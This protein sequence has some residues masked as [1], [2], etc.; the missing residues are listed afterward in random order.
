MYEYAPVFAKKKEKQMTYGFMALGL[1][2]Y[3]IGAFVP[4][5]PMPGLFQLL[6]VFCLVVMILL[7]S[8]CISKRYVYAVG[9]GDSGGVDFTITEYYGRRMMVVCRV[10]VESVKAA[11]P[12]NEETK[13]NFS[14][15]KAGNRV[16]NYTGVLFDEERWYLKIEENEERFLVQICAN[17]D[18]IRLLTG[19]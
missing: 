9:E 17:D 5:L 4:G 8:L 16:F 19:H 10:S 1:I 11:I 12:F 6:G 13:R 7:F 2:L 15:H 3:L 18:L 14:S